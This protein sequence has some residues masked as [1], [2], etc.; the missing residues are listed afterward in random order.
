VSETRETGS[1]RQEGR[2]QWGWFWGKKGFF[3]IRVSGSVGQLSQRESTNILTPLANAVVR[4]GAVADPG[5]GDSGIVDQATGGSE[6]RMRG[7]F[8]HE[9]GFPTGAVAHST[10]TLVLVSVSP[11]VKQ[12]QPGWESREVRGAPAGIG[13]HR[14]VFPL[15]PASLAIESP[16]F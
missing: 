6:G 11:R 15:P 5:V 3:G 4:L 8:G 16:G 14:G 13:G 7:V 1:R 10:A 12:E 2:G 9:S